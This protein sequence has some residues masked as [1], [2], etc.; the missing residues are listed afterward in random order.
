MKSVQVRAEWQRLEFLSD[1]HLHVDQP[2]TARAWQTHLLGSQA[3]AL[4]ILGDLFEV[5]IGDDDDSP[6][7]A[8]CIDTLAQA[9]RQRPIY[10]LCGNRDFLVGPSLM[11]RTGMQALHDP[12]VLDAGACRFLLS[13]GD[14][15]CVDDTAYLAFR[16]QVRSESWQ[17]D[18]LAHPLAQRRAV[19]RALREQSEA[20][21][22]TQSQYADIDADMARQWLT[23]AQAQLLIHGH[24]HRPGVHAF[25]AQ[26]S[27]WCLS[28]WDAQAHPPR[29]ECTVWQRSQLNN[30][31]WGLSREPLAP[32]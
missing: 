23:Q 1:V 15:L 16:Q 25:N 27:R 29:L 22:Q 5:W 32:L 30:G 19:A 11:Q 9:A 20:R 6:F 21:K 12:C 18:F 3:D 31:H 10:F 2:D 14:A 17:R 24:T 26:Q 28:D 13:H 7:V 4:F 8:S